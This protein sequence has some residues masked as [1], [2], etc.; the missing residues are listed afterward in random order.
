MNENESDYQAFPSYTTRSSNRPRLLVVLVV[1]FLL[2]F[3]VFG[4][5]FMLGAWQK[6][7]EEALPTPTVA[8]TAT[9][10]PTS[11]ASAV[12]TVRPTGATTPTVGLLSLDKSTNLDRSKLQVEVLNGSGETGAAGK[13]STY[14]EELGYQILKI[15]NAEAF[16]YRNLTI[17]VKKDKGAYSA[18][19]KKDLQANPDFASVSASIID[20]ISS[21]AVV[22]VGK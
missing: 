8:A 1:I 7:P 5:L 18:L 20:D 15:G 16:T 3:V 4:G 9:P 11:S 22:I 12:L 17:Q 21:D 13:V 19:L 10:L 14:L 6:K 2:L